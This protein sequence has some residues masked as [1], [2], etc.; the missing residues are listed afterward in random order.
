VTR[1]LKT[2]GSSGT[3]ITMLVSSGGAGGGVVGVGVSAGAAGGS[4]G[5]D[6]VACGRQPETNSVSN[7]AIATVARITL[8]ILILLFLSRSS[9]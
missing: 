8:F 3:R 6:G 7:T 2:P 1:L 5:G 9:C 4:S